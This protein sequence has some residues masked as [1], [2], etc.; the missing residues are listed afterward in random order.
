MCLQKIYDDVDIHT[1]N[2]VPFDTNMDHYGPVLVSVLLNKLPEDF[3]IEISWHMP[4]GK[5]KLEKPLSV[6]EQELLSRERFSNIS[7]TSQ[8]NYSGKY[9]ASVLLT[10]QT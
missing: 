8:N 3:K 7:Q 2:V 1:K 6:F 5:W 10:H 9:S 4:T